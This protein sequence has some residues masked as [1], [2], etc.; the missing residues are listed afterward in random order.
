[1]P[2]SSLFSSTD[3]SLLFRLGPSVSVVLE[4]TPCWHKAEALLRLPYC[5]SGESCQTKDWAS[6]KLACKAVSESEDYGEVSVKGFNKRCKES[7]TWFSSVPGLDLTVMRSAWW[8]FSSWM[9]LTHSLKAP[10]SN[11]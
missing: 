1:M 9:Q 6:H 7:T 3:R 8:G 5:R 10:G 2:H 11:P 4:A